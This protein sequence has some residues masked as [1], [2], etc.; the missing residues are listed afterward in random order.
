LIKAGS[1]EFTLIT[2]DEDGEKS[3]SWFRPFGQLCADCARVRAR[4]IIHRPVILDSEHVLK[5]H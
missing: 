2:V 3:A 4:A 5:R 1:V